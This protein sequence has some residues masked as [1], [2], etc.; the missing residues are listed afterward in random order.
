MRKLLNVAAV[1]V[2]ALIP[3][4]SLAAPALAAPSRPLVLQ[5][6]VTT[7]DSVYSLQHVSTSGGQFSVSGSKIEIF[8]LPTDG[9]V[10]GG[11]P[12]SDGRFDTLYAGDQV[13]QMQQSDSPGGCAG[14]DS[15]YHSG[16]VDGGCSIGERGLWV[17]VGRWFVNVGGTDH[18]DNYPYGEIMF[19]NSNFLVYFANHQAPNNDT[20]QWGFG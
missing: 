6:T 2:A 3:A 4:V 17:A 9:T 1:C 8:N 10:G 14:I 11:W 18:Y 5:A 13:F 15:A 16:V 19:R 20:N 7:W 12:F